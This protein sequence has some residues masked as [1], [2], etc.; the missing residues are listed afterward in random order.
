[1]FIV[2]TGS[3][4]YVQIISNAYYKNQLSELTQIIVEGSS[5]PRGRIY[6]RKGRIIVDNKA[7]KTI[8]YKKEPN[9][10]TKEEVVMAYKVAE[11]LDVNYSKLNDYDLR[12][13]WVI[14]NPLSS[15]K[16]ITDEEWKKLDERKITVDDIEAYKRERITKAELAEYKDIDKEAAYIYYLMN[17][18]YSYAEKNIKAEGVTDL[19]YAAIADNEENLPGFGTKLDWERTYPYGDVFRTI[20]GNVSSSNSGITAELKEY[21]TLVQVKFMD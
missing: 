8:Y 10:S 20:L 13:F 19:E 12:N 4:Y 16:K 7:V 3:L 18:G 21:Y 6:D 5:A 17:K 2:L 15:K 9:I 14:N 11:L 1:M